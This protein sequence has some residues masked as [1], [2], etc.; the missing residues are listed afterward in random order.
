MGERFMSVKTKR[1]SEISLSTGQL[2]S[3]EDFVQRGLEYV[4]NDYR[5]KVKNKWYKIQEELKRIPDAPCKPLD[6]Y[7]P[8][9]EEWIDLEEKKEKKKHLF[10][11]SLVFQNDAY[12]E[13]WKWKSR[14]RN[15]GYYSISINHLY[16][17]T[18]K[19]IYDNLDKAML[20]FYNQMKK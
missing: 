6:F 20:S 1:I 15:S 5:I 17:E 9:T 4:E 12:L 11:I 13:L 14:G 2:I 7:F 8:E 19:I 3:I 16:I 18:A 10:C